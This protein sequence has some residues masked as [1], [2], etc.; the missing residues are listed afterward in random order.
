MPWAPPMCV[1]VLRV[2]GLLYIP[3]RRRRTAHLADVAARRL[4]CTTKQGVAKTHSPL[5]DTAREPD[6]TSLE[7]PGPRR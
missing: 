1:R 3:R 7:C 4:N 2:R 6:K 5:S